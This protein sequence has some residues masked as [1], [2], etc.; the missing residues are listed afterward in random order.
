MR[1]AFII[2]LYPPYVVG[3]NEMITYGLVEALRRQGHTV[4]V[5][6][7]RGQE[8]CDEPNIHEVLNYDLEEKGLV[9]GG[10]R[11][12]LGQLFRHHV[13]DLKTYCDTRRTI[14]E[15]QPDLVVVDNQYMASAAPLLAVRDTPCPVIA[16]T[17]DKWLVYCLLNWELVVEPI[18]PLQKLFV[19]GVRE[20]IQRFLARKVRLDGIATVSDFIRKYYVQ[21]GF[22][23]EKIE[24]VYLGYDDAVFRPGSSHQLHEPVRLMF[25]G[26]LW[27]GKGPQIIVKALRTLNQRD[28][29]PGFQLDIFG[30]GTE[31]FE[32]YLRSVIKEAGATQQVFLHGFVP[33]QELVKAMHRSDI[34]VFS[35]IWDEPFATIPLQAAGCGLP[36]VA[37][38]AGGTPEG[39]RDEET[40]LLIPPGDAVAMADA[41]SRLVRD[42][43]LRE[44]IGKNAARA[45]RQ[46]WTFEAYVDRFWEFCT[47]TMH[48]WQ[49]NQTEE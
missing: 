26:S 22:S 9:F 44:R 29:L 25:A 42:D 10:K 13:F 38:R 2:N 33:W 37:T 8:L 17:M 28:E 15:I 49:Q 23:P 36:I 24:S 43:E 40:A 5:L 12:S 39:F 30:E 47:R 20:S 46:R 1:I 3:G 41:I 45:A 34:F 27:K 35:S 7:A 19:R 6:T 16:Q 4:H 21:A 11:L 14:N 48:R 18:G 32:K 31:R